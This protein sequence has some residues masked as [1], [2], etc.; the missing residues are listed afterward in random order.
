LG[1]SC[2]LKGSVDWFGS[3]VYSS[4]F[5]EA[6]DRKSLSQAGRKN[7]P[8]GDS[9]IFVIGNLI[10]FAFRVWFCELEGQQERSLLVQSQRAWATEK[11]RGSRETLHAMD[12]FYRQ[13]YAGPLGKNNI[14]VTTC[15]FSLWSTGNF[16]QHSQGCFHTAHQASFCVFDGAHTKIMKYCCDDVLGGMTPT[17]SLFL[18]RTDCPA[19][20]AS[21]GMLSMSRQRRSCVVE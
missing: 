12:P 3:C 19:R 16:Q 2:L 5:C 14:A 9:C 6:F 21:F 1:C 17:V 8:R 7:C 11:L 15:I 20:I 4:P 18:P 10:C 13:Y